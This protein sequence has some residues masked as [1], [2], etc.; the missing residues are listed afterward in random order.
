MRK[1]LLA[2]L[3]YPAL[4]AA[5]SGLI[6][7]AAGFIATQQF[8]D[9]PNAQRQLNALG[10]NRRLMIQEGIGDAQQ[11][12]DVVADELEAVAGPVDRIAFTDLT[13]KWRNTFIEVGRV[14]WAPRITSKQRAAHEAA[15][16]MD[17]VA[18][19]RIGDLAADGDRVAAS[20]RAEYFPLAYIS[21]EQGV[22]PIAG[23]DLASA[24]KLR[25]AMDRAIEDGG[26]V[27]SQVAL[28]PTVSGAKK[29]IVLFRPVYTKDMPRANVDERRHA[30]IG[31]VAGFASQELLLDHVLAEV[32][33]EGIDISLYSRDSG[34]DALPSY[35]RSSMLRAVPTTPQPRG[36][37]ESGLHWASDLQFADT[38]WDMVVTLIPGAPMLAAY[39]QAWIILVAGLLLTIAATTQ[40]AL[41]QRANALIREARD[42][43]SFSN[44]LLNTAMEAT[45][46]G[47]LIV[48]ERMRVLSSNRR[49]IELF[50]V[51]SELAASD[52]D[53]KI[54]AFCTSQIEEPS[55]FV[56]RVRH[57]YKHPEEIAHEDIGLRDGR[58]F[59]RHSAPLFDAAKRYL[60]RIW[61]FR[62]V[63]NERL[64]VRQLTAEARA[65]ALTG[66]ANR[67]T[68]EERLA[69]AIAEAKRGGP[70]FA[71]F[72]L[73]LDHFK[74]INDTLGHAA[75]D[76]VLAEVGR[77]LRALIRETDLVARLGG[78]EFAVL[79]ANVADAVSAGT[80]AEKIRGVLATPYCLEGGQAR[81]TTSIGISMWSPA[82]ATSNK[83]LEQ[84]DGALYRAKE[85]GRDRFCFAESHLAADVVSPQLAE[86]GS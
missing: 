40:T 71:V 10:E 36:A 5:A 6:M 60:G 32:H 75:G 58:I 73:D 38:R 29:V 80:I 16:S 61:F 79:L 74:V 24:P 65:D 64:A 57:L 66:I 49:F 26:R 77:R 46:D 42:R 25:Q 14:G 52:D 35:V 63:T 70:G 23:I 4:I 8:W 55:E 68:F 22:E 82:I 43:L 83:L 31:F 53:E 33:P 50:R 13:E 20:D 27:T 39:R 59:D 1:N 17:G 7:S 51:P 18:G 2:K 28:L 56:A 62:D 69:L 85:Q 45:P 48:N 67:R 11:K 54:L 81:A 72:A 78:D 84:A 34:S 44:L 15:V 30:L 76:A 21:G 19:Y 47:M 12:I 86:A 37:L 9:L 3:R 41:A